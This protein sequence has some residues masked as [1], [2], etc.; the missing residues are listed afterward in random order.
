LKPV[1]PSWIDL[2][3]FF[4]CTIAGLAF[5]DRSQR[6]VGRSFVQRTVDTFAALALGI[7]MCVSQTRA[8]IEGCLPGTGVF[9]RT[10]KRGDAKS[11]RRYAAV[12]RGLPGIELLLAAWFGWGIY[13]AAERDAWM[14]L[15][16]LLLFFVSFA[17][18]GGMSL[19]DALRVPNSR[20]EP[21]PST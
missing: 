3:V 15:P 16:I 11:P 10:P 13:A 9:E 20:A 7:G 6:A 21:S 2:T 17:W 19:A 1:L 8:V 4:A 5:Y 18:V 14:S 12:V